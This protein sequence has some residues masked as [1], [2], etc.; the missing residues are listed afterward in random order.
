M[1]GWEIRDSAVE[2][3][4]FAR[5]RCSR[6]V[7]QG[8][9]RFAGEATSQDALLGGDDEALMTPMNVGAAHVV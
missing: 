9:C 7:D 6:Q 3:D 1:L 8:V 5:L 2:Q 4:A